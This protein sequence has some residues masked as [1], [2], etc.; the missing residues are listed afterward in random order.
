MRLPL[1]QNQD[2]T[3]RLQFFL[4][5]LIIFLAMGGENT[6]AVASEF[7]G[8][9]KRANFESGFKMNGSLDTYRYV[10]LEFKNLDS[11]WAVGYENESSLIGLVGQYQEYRAYV[12]RYGDYP[13]LPDWKNTAWFIGVSLSGSQFVSSALSPDLGWRTLQ[14][15]RIFFVPYNF[16]EDL[17]FYTNAIQSKTKLEIFPWIQPWDWPIDIVPEIN[18]L[19][20][21]PF[22]TNTS[23]SMG[24]GISVRARWD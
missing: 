10:S 14:T 15:Q 12:H 5:L 9:L 4:S 16:Y 8:T 13:F 22:T 6:R 3:M 20:F 23:G 1:E 21:G 17:S 11:V 18:Y 24:T 2:T 7:L 19:W